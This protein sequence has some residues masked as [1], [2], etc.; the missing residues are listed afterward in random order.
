MMTMTIF[1]LD[2][3]KML[4]PEELSWCVRDDEIYSAEKADE[5]RIAHVFASLRNRYRFTSALWGNISALYK[6]VAGPM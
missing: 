2:H 6:S 4:T 3:L 5:F 1:Y